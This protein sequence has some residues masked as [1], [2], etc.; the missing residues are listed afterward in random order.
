MRGI[1]ISLEGQD[2]SG[3]TTAARELAA[4]VRKLGREVVLTR[5]P[6]G[7]ALG[8]RL[9]SIL[10]DDESHRI[11]VAAEALLFAASRAQLVEEVIRPALERGAVVISDRFT[12]SSLAY[13]WGARGLPL[14]HLQAAQ[15]L[16]TGNLEPDLTFLLD[17][18]VEQSLRRQVGRAAEA[19]RLDRESTSFHDGVRQAYHSLA[20]ANPTRWRV[21]DAAQDVEQVAD[22]IWCLVEESGLLH[23]DAGPAGHESE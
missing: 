21:I 23:A 6:G 16:A 2:G 22:D 10:L 13:Q 19:N 17:L 12:D 11:S 4:A 7:T 18:S 8:E 20:A 9:R 14:E 15:A 1:F 3:K 5:E